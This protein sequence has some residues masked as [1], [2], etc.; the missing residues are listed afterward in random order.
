MTD[1]NAKL[2]AKL[3]D[4]LTHQKYSPV[5]VANYCSYAVIAHP[6]YAASTR[7]A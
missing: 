6:L 7:I 4:V 3:G 1:T 2:I 5:V